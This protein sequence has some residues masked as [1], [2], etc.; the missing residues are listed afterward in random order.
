M[1]AIDDCLGVDQKSTTACFDQWV[2]RDQ[3]GL[4]LQQ[5]CCVQSNAILAAFPGHFAATKARTTGISHALLNL[6]LQLCFLL[7]AV[8]Q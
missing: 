1:I 2:L 5:A 3:F 7:L 4:I 8:I 6:L